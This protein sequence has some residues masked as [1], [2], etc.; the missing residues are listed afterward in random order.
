MG[1]VWSHSQPLAR[2]DDLNSPEALLISCLLAYSIVHKLHGTIM[3]VCMYVV[4]S[5]CRTV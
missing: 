2:A 5:I 1:L 4:Y 3:Y